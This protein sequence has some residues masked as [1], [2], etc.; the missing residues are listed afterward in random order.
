L[1]QEHVSQKVASFPVG[2]CDVTRVVIPND[3][4]AHVIGRGGHLIKELSVIASIQRIDI[5]LETEMNRYLF[6]SCV[7]SIFNFICIRCYEMSDVCVFV[8]VYFLKTGWNDDDF[9]GQFS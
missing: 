2:T 8:A 6:N 4:V 9:D 7:Y 5:Q 1:I 3:V